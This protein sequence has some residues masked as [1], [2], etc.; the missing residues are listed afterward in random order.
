MRKLCNQSKLEL[1]DTLYFV[2]KSKLVLH[3]TLSN[4][5]VYKLPSRNILS[6]TKHKGKTK[7]A[8]YVNNKIKIIIDIHSYCFLYKYYCSV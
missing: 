1:V 2:L 7:L 6:M 8:L 3:F 4:K 5:Y